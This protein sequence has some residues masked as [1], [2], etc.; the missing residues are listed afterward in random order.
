[1]D[2]LRDIET[3]HLEL[4]FADLQLVETRIERIKSGKKITKENLVELAA[5]EKCQAVLVDEKPASTAELTDEER[6]A[7]RHIAFLSGKPTVLV[8]NVDE[9]QR[10]PAITLAG[11]RCA[12]TP[13]SAVFRCWKSAPTVEAE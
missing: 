8:V 13:R 11:R 1:M 5:M 12:N 10:L 7:L 2:P 4:L 3:L 9:Q 6:E